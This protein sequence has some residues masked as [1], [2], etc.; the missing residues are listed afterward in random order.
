MTDKRIVLTT[1]GSEDEARKIAHYLVAQRLAACVNI[2]PRI[3]SI[4]R[5]KEKVESSQEYLLLIKTSA[6][7]FPQVRDAIRELHSYELPECVAISIEDGSPEYLQWLAYSL[8][9]EDPSE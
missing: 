4:Y 5:W 7:R 3:E 8:V 1:A 9:K 6:G 2:I